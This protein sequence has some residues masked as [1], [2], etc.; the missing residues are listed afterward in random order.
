[1]N[2]GLGG[3]TVATVALGTFMCSF[4]STAVNLALP[5]IQHSYGSHIA[6]AE[7]IAVAYLLAVSASLL[8]F[9]RLA[10][11]WGRRRVYSSGFAGFTVSSLLSASS[12]TISAL[13]M[14]RVLQG[15]FGSLMMASA[16]AVILGAVPAS[17]RGRA[18]GFTAVAVA[19]GTSAGPALGGLLATTFG[20]KSIFLVNLPIGVVGTILAVT[21]IKRDEKQ[22]AQS[23]D[24]IGSVLVAAAL[25]AI[26]L[27]LDLLSAG[28]AMSPMV[29]S[30]LAFGITLG[31]TFF[32]FERSR[33]HPILSIHL[34]KNRAFTAG[35][36]AAILFYV[37][38]FIMLF[39]APYFLQGLLGLSLREK[40]TASSHL[41]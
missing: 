41:G 18:L 6:T 33:T 28:M 40:I 9:G 19:L 39:L 26:L 30:L 23:F 13:V 34:F 11:M 5:L 8:T 15:L 37:S 25:C 32:L 29:W 10:D 38:L 12:P 36:I 4:D 35:N 27:S 22:S 21:V 14:C 16:Y 2:K 7:W 1:M 17:R 24:P 3:A 20:W 31:V